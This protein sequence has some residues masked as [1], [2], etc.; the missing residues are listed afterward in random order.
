MEISLY[1][2]LPFCCNKIINCVIFNYQ[3]ASDLLSL[4]TLLAFNADISLTNDQ[5]ET[6]FDMAKKSGVAEIVDILQQLQVNN[7]QDRRHSS[8]DFDAAMKWP[9]M[10][11]RQASVTAKPKCPDGIAGQRKAY[12]DTLMKTFEKFQGQVEP[13]VLDQLLACAME[14]YDYSVNQEPVGRRQRKGD[15]MLCLDG[16]GIRG[17]IL[18]ELLSAIEEISGS[19]IIDLFD[20]IIGTSTGGILALAIVYSKLTLI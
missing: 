2:I 16:G 5:E 11:N 13:A 7:D 12:V 3:Q 14:S 10:F 19:K 9:P 18:I 15:R 20:W 4:K 8:I 6:P 1:L 17:L